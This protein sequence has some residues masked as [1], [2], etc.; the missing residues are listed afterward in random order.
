M[1]FSPA[2]PSLV[3][4]SSLH[5]AFSPATP[6]LVLPSSLH[7]FLASNTILTRYSL[8]QPRQI[9]DYFKQLFAQVTNPPIDPIR[10]ELVM[11]LVCPVGPEENLL[12]TPEGKVSFIPSP[13]ALRKARMRATTNPF[14][15]SSFGAALQSP[16]RDNSCA[17]PGGDADAEEFRLNG[18]E[19]HH[20]FFDGSH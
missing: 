8:A 18:Q 19:W 16:P 2:T 3:L 9:G 20:S 14:A 6:S 15:P 13:L 11:S 7:G 1:A 12:S 17:H 10:E 5:M 4:P